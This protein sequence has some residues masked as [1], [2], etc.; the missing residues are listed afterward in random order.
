MLHDERDALRAFVALL[1]QE[2]QV[3]LGTDTDPLLELAERKT[4]SADHLSELGRQ[5]QLQLPPGASLASWIEQHAPASAA[6]WQ[7]ILTL[8]EQAR[9]LNQTNG[10][11]IQ[12]RMRYNQQALQVLIGAT[13]QASALYGPNGQTALPATGRALGSG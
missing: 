6:V 4:R 1:E 5:R 7:N 9:Q 8:A 10:N 3:L 11:L 13:Q 2:Q 12:T